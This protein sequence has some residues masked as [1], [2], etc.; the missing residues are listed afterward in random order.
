MS[1]QV[2]DF[3]HWIHRSSQVSLC[4]PKEEVC[5]QVESAG[6]TR[7]YQAA[8]TRSEIIYRA[9]CSPEPTPEEI[10]QEYFLLECD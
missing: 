7:I 9:L 2:I 5:D 10:M 1:A 4:A 3:G 8:R 6:Q